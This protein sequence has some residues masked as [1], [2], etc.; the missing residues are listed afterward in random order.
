MNTSLVKRIEDKYKFV[1]DRMARAARS[2]GRDPESVRLVV[3]TKG[4]SL[5]TVR[6][7]VEVGIQDIG[8]NYVE[9][10]E[11]KIRAVSD[12]DVC[13]HMIGHIQSRKAKPV[14]RHFSWVHS[15]DRLKIARRLSRYAGEMGLTIPVLLECNVSGE[16]SKYGWSAW[17][18]DG[19]SEFAE[20][21]VPVLEYP[22]IQVRGLMTMPP[23]DPDPE[24]ARPFFV[25]LRRLRDFLSECYPQANWHELSMGMS[26]DYEIAIQEG[27]TVVRI[28][29]AILG[30]RH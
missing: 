18:E 15:L 10:A 20:K 29:T 26:N 23:Y 12:S 6:S 27:A 16:V 5:E 24:A 2:V 3:V 25:R 8:E 11:P 19:W 17:I 7:T 4:H 13:W 28:G 1:L 21:L 14:C 9:E 22:H 30:P